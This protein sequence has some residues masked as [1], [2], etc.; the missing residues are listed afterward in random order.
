MVIM[1]IPKNVFSKTIAEFEAEVNKYTA[2]L[3]EKKE[4]KAKND[5]EVAQVE[6][7]IKN[8]ES[9]IKATEDEI[10]ELERQIEESN[11]KILEKN[12]ESKK[13]VQYYQ[14]ENGDNVYLEYVFGAETITDMI[15]RMSITEQ[16]TE[17]NRQIMQELRR[18]IDENNKKKATLATKKDELTSLKKQLES[19]KSRIEADTKGLVAS[20]PSIETRIKEARD[21]LA[22]YKRLGCGKTEDIAA[23]QFRIMQNSGGGGGGSLPSVGAFQRPIEYGTFSRGWTGNY[24]HRGVDMSSRNKNIAVHPIAEG[25]IA[26]I[27]QDSCNN[28]WCSR[29][30]SGAYC[31]GNAKIVVVRHNYNGR[32]IYS[33]YVHLSS[34][35]NF[36]VGDR[37]TKDSIIGYMGT[38][39]CSTGEHLHL[40]VTY[41]HWKTQGGCTYQT[42]Q[43]QSLN[44]TS[45]GIS[46]PSSWNNF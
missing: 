42:F 37:V 32:Y 15:Y 6:R 36:G 31:H 41:C 46:F 44:P 21:N 5:A 34:Y 23:C 16:L 40:E 1:L 17:Y 35:G 3:T 4:K 18:L 19:E 2:E 30:A 39:G 27:Y 45:L 43:K 13:I 25:A 9:Q 10:R 29:Q 11:Q 22:Y 8:I 12:E 7:N 38:T 24:G 20:M 28:G 33:M 14:I 26:A